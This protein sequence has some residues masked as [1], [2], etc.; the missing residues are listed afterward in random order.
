MKKTEPENR[1]L[2]P[3]LFDYILK[4]YD[5]Q[6]CH[7]TMNFKITYLSKWR[8]GM[9]KSANPNFSTDGSRAHGGVLATL[10]DT[11]MSAAAHTINGILYRTLEMNINYLAPAYEDTELIAEAYVI[12]PG[13]KIAVVESNLFDQEG[14]PIA[15]SRGTYIKD[16]KNTIG[17]FPDKD[18]LIWV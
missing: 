1:G 11:V 4:L 14:T 8:A 12:Y 5:S 3:D 16:N 18:Q 10:A 7:Q 9:K 15:K 6:K 2:E 13:Q 17:C